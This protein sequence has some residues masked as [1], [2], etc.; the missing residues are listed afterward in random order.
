M[1]AENIKNFTL[2][3]TN[4]AL[5]NDIILYIKKKFNLFGNNFLNS[6]INFCNAKNNFYL[7]QS[8]KSLKFPNF[9]WGSAS[10]FSNLIHHRLPN[11][12]E[13]KDT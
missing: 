5:L 7:S 11:R 4:L 9:I 13:L 12:Y 6:L 2:L 8:S 3:A 10:Y 1:E